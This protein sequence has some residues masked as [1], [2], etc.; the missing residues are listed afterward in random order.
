MTDA[1]K[2]IV[3]RVS[4]DDGELLSQIDTFR[5]ADPE[6]DYQVEVERWIQDRLREWVFAHGA[7]DDEPQLLAVLDDQTG[8]LVGVFA[9]EHA[10]LQRDGDDRPI[11][12]E[13]ISVVAVGMRF[14]GKRDV[15]NRRYS[16]I[17][18]SSGLQAVEA[19]TPPE[20]RVFGLV[21]I[22]NEDSFRLLERH[23][24]RRRITYD[25]M[26]VIVTHD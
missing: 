1:T 12:A 20:R 8:E 9:H 14:Q 18:M 17:V 15:E 25:S 10:F 2:V 13:K 5:C 22:D 16:D 19:R 3:R 24:M 26:T 4:P 21:H 11:P 7:S 6:L 23:N